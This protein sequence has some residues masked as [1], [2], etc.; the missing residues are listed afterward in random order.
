VPDRSASDDVTASTGSDPPDDSGLRDPN[1]ETGLRD[2][3]AETGLRHRSGRLLRILVPVLA[4]GVLAVAVHRVPPPAPGAF[5]GPPE[6][7]PTGPPGALIRQEPISSAPAGATAWRILYLSTDDAGRAVPVSGVVV[8]P[9]APAP[10][11][12]RPVVA[13][14]HPTTGVASRCAPSLAPDAGLSRIPGLADL[15]AAG[16]A[17]TATDYPGLGTAGPHPYLIGP[18]EGRAVLDSVRATRALTE[19]GAGPRTAV[20][21]HSQGGHAALFAAQLAPGYSADVP[22]AGVAA[23]APVTDLT[24]LL[25]HDIGSVAGNVLTSLALVSWSQVHAGDGLRLDDVLEPLSVPIAERIA[26]QCTVAGETGPAGGVEGTGDSRP[27]E[28]PIRPQ[29]AVDMPSAEIL[30]MRVLHAQPWNVSGWDTRLAES[31]PRTG[32]A[33]PVLV[34]QGTADTVVWRDVTGSWVTAQCGQGADV[35][36]RQYDDV[37]HADIADRSASDTRAWLAERFAGRPSA[38]CR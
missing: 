25:Q 13:W 24:A 4:V 11:G 29:L 7:M 16:Y 1:A 12:G 21:G 22:L 38:G 2:P 19:V 31:T 8:A 10:P 33:V 23:A 35:T 28:V 18:S 14:A 20:W 32:G 3:N 36:L 26:A 30:R 37:T 6:P 5:Y 15:L 17:V 27:P 34:A 9:T